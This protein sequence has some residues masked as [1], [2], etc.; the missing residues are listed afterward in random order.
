LVRA[1]L[2]T[3]LSLLRKAPQAKLAKLAPV[4]LQSLLKCLSV[5]TA[6]DVVSNA[7]SGVIRCLLYDATAL[8]CS[9]QPDLLRGNIQLPKYFFQRLK[10]EFPTVRHSL[11]NAASVLAGVYVQR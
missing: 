8:L 10:L 7:D 1:G 4:L 3:L 9:N 2:D 6:A 11:K 5:H